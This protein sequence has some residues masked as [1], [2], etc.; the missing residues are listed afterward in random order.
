[1]QEV[2]GLAHR[3]VVMRHGRTVGELTGNRINEGEII[4]LAMGVEDADDVRNFGN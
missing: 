3:V 4:K 1:M 2:V